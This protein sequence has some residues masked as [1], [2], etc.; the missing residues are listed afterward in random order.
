[1]TAYE[2]VDLAI[3]LGNRIDVQ[4]GIFITVHLA[5]FGGI[6]YVDRPLRGAE[7]AGSILLYLCFAGLNFRMMQSQLQILEGVYSQINTMSTRP[8]C[9]DFPVLAH[10]ADQFRH[11]KFR[12]NFMFLVFSHLLMLLLVIASILLDNQVMRQMFSASSPQ[13]D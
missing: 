3:S 13:R 7:K 4:I 6:I 10:M 1:M 12:L 9:S 2:L 8:C 11:G 5:I